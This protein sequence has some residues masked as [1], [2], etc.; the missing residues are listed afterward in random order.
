LIHSSIKAI[1]VSAVQSGAGTKNVLPDSRSTPPNTHCPLTGW[2]LLAPTKFALV[3]LDDL[4]K[5]A[6]LLRAALQ[7]FEYLLS[8]ELASVQDRSWTEAMLFF[9]TVGRYAA[10]DVCE[11][12]NLEGDV[13]VL[14]H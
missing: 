3:N 6:D 8:T 5:T 11:K 13:T 4:V 12:H 10:H 14:M 2:P 9:D 1:K 7:V